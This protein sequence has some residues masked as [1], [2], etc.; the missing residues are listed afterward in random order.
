MDTRTHRVAPP[1]DYPI[2]RRD[3]GYRYT[4]ADRIEDLLG[5]RPLS[6]LVCAGVA[7]FI[8]VALAVQL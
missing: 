5:M 1:L 3:F 8:G 4:L 6:L 7:G 2:A